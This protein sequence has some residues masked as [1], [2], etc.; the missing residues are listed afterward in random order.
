M[1][2]AVSWTIFAEGTFMFLDGGLLDF[3]VIGDSGLD[4][5]NDY[6]THDGDV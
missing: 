6:E 3:Q 5:T 1:A 4:S 2:D